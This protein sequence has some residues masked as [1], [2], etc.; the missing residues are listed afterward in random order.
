MGRRHVSS[1]L[2]RTAMVFYLPD[3]RAFWVGRKA[4][5]GRLPRARVFYYR[6]PVPPPD[7]VPMRVRRAR[8]MFC[9]GA[10]ERYRRFMQTEDREFQ[11]DS[12]HL[13]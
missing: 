2:E 12:E 3:A 6:L 11:D 9:A 7:A 13:C 10:H 5:P 1:E 8:Q 4:A